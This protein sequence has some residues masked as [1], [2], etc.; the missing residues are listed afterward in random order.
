[1]RQEN[2]CDLFTSA[3]VVTCS[4]TEV[5]SIP[6]SLG[7]I[8]HLKE[9]PTMGRNPLRGSKCKCF[10]NVIQIVSLLQLVYLPPILI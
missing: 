8:E 5:N 4:E 3:P 7:P 10:F 9:A 6:T 2:T 1:M